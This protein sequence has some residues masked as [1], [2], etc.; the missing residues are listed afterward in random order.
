MKS[1]T[2][3]KINTYYFCYPYSKDWLMIKSDCDELDTLINYL[4]NMYSNFKSCYLLG[5]EK[6]FRMYKVETILRV[7]MSIS[8]TLAG[9]PIGAYKIC[10]ENEYLL[11][12]SQKS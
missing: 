8:N 10:T 4:N 3:P 9:S 5:S 1:D 6:G 12:H 7:G 2:S 11:F